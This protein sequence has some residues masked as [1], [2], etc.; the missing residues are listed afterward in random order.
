[1]RQLGNRVLRA[2]IARIAA[3]A[4]GTGPVGRAAQRDAR[5]P[6]THVVLLDGTMG[7]LAPG[8]GTHIGTIFRMLQE[9]PTRLSLY[10]APGLSW[11]HWS[12]LPDVAQ[13]R[14]VESQIRRAYGW[15]ATR[16][17][18]GDRIYL[19]GYS[20]GAFAVRSLARMIS[21]VGLLRPEAALQRNVSLV[22][23]YYI[24]RGER[25]P[26]APHQRAEARASFRQRYCHDNTPITAIGAF[27]TVMAVGV[28]LPVLW[29][30]TQPAF[31]FEDRTLSDGVQA[32]FHALAL[33]ETR[34]VFEPI[35]WRTGSTPDSRI[36]QLWFR[37]SHADIGGQ[38][39]G[40]ESARPLAN[41]PLVWML[42]ELEGQGLPLPEGWRD[43][44]HCDVE[45]PSVGSWRG[46][47]KLMLLR[48]PRLVGRDPTEAI[49]ES[50]QD[51][52]AQHW[53]WRWMP[54]MGRRGA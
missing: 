7:A 15:L 28:R 19:I 46:L 53:V 48:A 37:G 20:R 32:A 10:Y 26:S 18:P 21:E 29:A 3:L 27:D 42:S 5:G 45:A 13:G 51:W 25:S 30:L 17:Q 41:I 47:G 4:R 6:L 11:A 39:G 1:M 31:R 49:H 52:A 40:D 35:L 16:W 50:A 2:M 34:S 9:T 22:W 43:A 8:M 33:D 54:G 12:D 24:G 38:L 23:R 44:L 36:R 14:G